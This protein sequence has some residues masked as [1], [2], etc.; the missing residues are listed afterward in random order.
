MSADKISALRCPQCGQPLIRDEAEASDML[1][2]PVHGPIGRFHEMA[3][4]EVSEILR[5]IREALDK[6]ADD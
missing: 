2:C 6:N 5:E 3:K 1:S 4:K